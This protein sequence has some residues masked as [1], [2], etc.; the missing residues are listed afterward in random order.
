MFE[1]AFK[2]ID[3]ILHSMAQLLDRMAARG[4]EEIRLELQTPCAGA[5]GWNLDYSMKVYGQR[6]TEGFQVKW[7]VRADFA[8]A[9]SA[10]ESMP[11]VEKC[12]HSRARAA[13][14][15]AHAGE[16]TGGPTTPLRAV[17]IYTPALSKK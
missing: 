3:D 7:Q 4:R 2:N 12:Q 17:R 13:E 14:Y 1:Q 15:E 8:D 6:L 11:G 16:I 9:A 10:P 5:G